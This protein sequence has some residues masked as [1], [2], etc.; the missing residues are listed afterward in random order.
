MKFIRLLTVLVAA[1]FALVGCGGG[2]GGD[3]AG[4]AASP[5]PGITASNASVGVVFTDHPVEG[6][7]KA[8][9]TISGIQLIGDDGRVSL[10]DGPPVTIDLLALRDYQELFTVAEDVPPGVY[11]KIRLWLDDLQ[12][13]KVDDMGVEIEWT[14][15]RL[16]AN[17]KVDLIPQAP[18]A[19]VADSSLFITLD[20]DMKKSIKLTLSGK[21]K[22]P[23]LRPV[24]F[25]RISE[26]DTIGRIARIKGVVDEIDT[27]NSRFRLCET[28]RVSEVSITQPDSSPSQCL[29]ITTGEQTSLFDDNG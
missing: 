25:V 20:F 10:Y 24:I 15:V 27:A 13:V 19:V 14:D 17:G 28:Q 2:G 4:S 21:K 18:F 12:L 22:Q 29:L 5:A 3:V 9:A 6:Y 26:F 8:L 1:T 7:D 11:S 23:K 16:V